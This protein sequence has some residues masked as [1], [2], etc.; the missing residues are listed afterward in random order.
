MHPL[1]GGFLRTPQVETGIDEGD[2]SEGLR[3]VADQ[4]A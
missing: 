3:E 1:L 4:P 2:V